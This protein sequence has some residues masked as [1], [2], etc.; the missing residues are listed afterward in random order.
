MLEH[1]ISG[2]PVMVGDK[3][4]GLITDGD[5]LRTLVSKA[6]ASAF[7]KSSRRARCAVV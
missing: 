3:L 7:D 5:I 1:G 2:L 4:L 6:T